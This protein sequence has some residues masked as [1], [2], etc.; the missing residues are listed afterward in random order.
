M[1]VC[2]VESVSTFIWG[3]TLL[4]TAR[5]RCDAVVVPAIPLSLLL[6][7]FPGAPTTPDFVIAA[8]RITTNVPLYT[9]ALS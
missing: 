6:M 8:A 5:P 4:H 2:V 3:V 1:V 7:T 9:D